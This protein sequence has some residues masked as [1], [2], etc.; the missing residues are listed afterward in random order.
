M[1]SACLLS[2]VDSKPAAAVPHASPSVT[3]YTEEI[4]DVAAPHTGGRPLPAVIPGEPALGDR[5]TAAGVQWTA[6][7]ENIGDGG[8]VSD[9][10]S[11][12]AQMA[13]SLTNST[14]A[15]LAAGFS[16]PNRAGR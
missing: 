15:E 3:T 14:L 13:V 6:A 9:S 2:S 16:A 12:I 11:P 5:E 1:I 10:Q 8:P 4:V 7:G